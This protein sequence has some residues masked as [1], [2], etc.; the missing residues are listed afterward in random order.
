MSGIQNIGG[1]LPAL[2]SSA[3]DF[4][5]PVNIQL[6]NLPITLNNSWVPGFTSDKV[7]YLYLANGTETQ[8]RRYDTT[9]GTWS[10]LPGAL[11]SAGTFTGGGIIYVNGKIYAHKGGGTATFW[12][13]DIAGGTWATLLPMT[14]ISNYAVPCWD[15]KDFIYWMCDATVSGMHRYSIA[16][17][18]WTALAAGGFHGQ[19][20]SL[21]YPGGDIIYSSGNGS[22]QPSMGMMYSISNNTW[23]SFNTPYTKYTTSGLLT[24]FS[25]YYPG[26][27]Y[28]Y[29]LV[30]SI[31]YIMYYDLLTK[32]S[33]YISHQSFSGALTNPAFGSGMKFSTVN[34]IIYCL[35][36]INSNAFFRNNGTN[37]FT[38]KSS[39]LV[40]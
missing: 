6:P 15:G 39:I 2:D 8:L 9:N 28:M 20:T 32:D 10:V 25:F 33:S 4:A 3:L 22:A 35:Y 18:S 30:D 37:V 16:G 19:N 5:S 36:G 11:P 38:A 40:P 17:N 12:S 27:R 23:T 7:R 29:Q 34:G 24:R 13:Y 31:G 21:I 26:G 1:T 14:S